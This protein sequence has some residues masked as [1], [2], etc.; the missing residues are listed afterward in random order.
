LL[1]A[2]AHYAGSSNPH[3]HIEKNIFFF[4][5]INAFAIGGYLILGGISPLKQLSYFR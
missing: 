3:S 4:Y 5:A 2:P 1:K